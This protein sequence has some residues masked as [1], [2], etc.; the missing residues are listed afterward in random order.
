VLGRKISLE[1]TKSIGLPAEPRRWYNRGVLINE[2]S[3]HIRQQGYFKVPN[4]CSKPG[5]IPSSR[6]D[7]CISIPSA[8]QNEGDKSFAGKVLQSPCALRRKYMVSGFC[9][10]LSATYNTKLSKSAQSQT[11]RAGLQPKGTKAQ[12]VGGPASES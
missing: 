12:L 10:I 1:A 2:M 11:F 9:L 6:V 3:V 5:R 8:S 4:A 7:A